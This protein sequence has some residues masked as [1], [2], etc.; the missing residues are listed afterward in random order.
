M[1]LEI[2]EQETSAAEDWRWDAVSRRDPA[3][4]GTFVY[5]VTSTHIFCRPSCPSRRPLRQRVRFFATADAAEAAGYRACRR[6]HPRSG[7]APVVRRVQVARQYLDEHP[8]ETVT[9]DRLGEIARMS[10]YHLQRTFKRLIGVSPKAYSNAHRLERMKHRLKKGDTVSRATYE[11]G[12]GSGSRVYE[13]ARS[14]LGMTPGNYRKGGRG[15]RVTYT[16]VSTSFGQLLVAATERGLCA[17]MLGDEISALEANLKREFPAA[18]IA[19]GNGELKHY[20]EELIQRLAGQDRN[21]LP[22]DLR[23]SAFQRQV[24]DALRRI[25]IGETRSYQAIARE[26]GRPSAARAVARACATNPV[27]VVVPC[28]RVVRQDGALSS[29]RWGMERKRLLLERERAQRG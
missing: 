15:M 25:P 20:T 5:G 7:Q 24:W 12:Y 14:E 3:Q 2:P 9:L 6:C 26:I 27:A 10:P 11:A 22:L 19:Q 29:Y 4:D 17:V 28:H 13:Q 18:T 23:G 1:K 16:V 21:P 8:D